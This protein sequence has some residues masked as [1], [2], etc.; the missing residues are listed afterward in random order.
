MTC[1]V[2]Q[3]DLDRVALSLAAPRAPGVFSIHD[4]CDCCLPLLMR[5]GAGGSGIARQVKRLLE[6]RA[7]KPRPHAGLSPSWWGT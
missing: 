7:R 6:H 1:V 5:A 2:C 3:K 4:I